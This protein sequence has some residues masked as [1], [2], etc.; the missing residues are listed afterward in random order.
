[1]IKINMKLPTL[2]GIETN[3]FKTLQI[4]YAEILIPFLIKLMVFFTG[5]PDKSRFQLKYN[6]NITIDSLFGSIEL[7]RNNN[8]H[9]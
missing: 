9:N 3:I 8:C 4:T 1:M 5:N 2:K 7:N 6:L